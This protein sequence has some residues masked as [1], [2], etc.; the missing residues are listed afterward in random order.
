[1]KRRILIVLF[2]LGTIGGFASGVSSMRWRA[3]HRRAA[4]EQH[5]AR[6][7]VDAARASQAEAN[8][9]AAAGRDE[10]RDETKTP[11]AAPRAD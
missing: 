7:C 6:V 8:A 9:A 5:V 1:M 10:R 11:A 3:H 4:F 2:A